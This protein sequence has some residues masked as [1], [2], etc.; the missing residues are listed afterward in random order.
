MKRNPA[1]RR[2]AGFT[3]IEVLAALV[4]VNMLLSAYLV[5]RY[6]DAVEWGIVLRRGIVTMGLGVAIGMGLY[7]LQHRVAKTAKQKTGQTGKRE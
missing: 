4:P 1:H 7:R 2:E 5:L 3:L 6:R